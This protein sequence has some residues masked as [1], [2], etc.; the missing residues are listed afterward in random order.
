MHENLLPEWEGR[1]PEDRGLE[2]VAEWARK[3]SLWVI[4]YGTGC[5]AI[6]VPPTM[7]SRYDA[8]RF[9]ITMMAT[10]RFS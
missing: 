2:L 9:G 4:A 5:G 10:P 3:H 1:V 7:T 8:E 6:E